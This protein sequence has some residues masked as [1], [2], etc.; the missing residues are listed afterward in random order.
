M[1]DLISVT[2]DSED[3]LDLDDFEEEEE[4]F[5][6]C[7]ENLDETSSL[8][9][10]SSMELTPMEEQPPMASSKAAQKAQQSLPQI[11]TTSTS[12]T[13]PGHN[14]N[15]RRA[16]SMRETTT[17][18]ST[19]TASSGVSSCPTTILILVAHGGSVLDL[20]MEASVRK[21]DVT[22]FRGALESV[23]RLHYPSLVGHVVVKCVA[24]PPI[25]SEALALLSSLS[26]YRYVYTEAFDRGEKRESGGKM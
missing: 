22:T 21:S 16:Q 10:W 26:P 18:T 24:S 14:I 15:V 25:C 17:T 9:K 5:F 11:V 13:T 3:D 6:D 23:M 4:E 7:R 20:D 2:Q 12:L 19:T 8:A 1:I